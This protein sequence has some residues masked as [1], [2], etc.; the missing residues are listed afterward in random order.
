MH[1]GSITKL[2]NVVLLMQMVDERKVALED[3]VIKY[4][5][6]LRLCDREA[7]GRITVQM[8]V[9]HTSGIDGLWLPE[10]GPDQERIVDLIDRCADL[11]QLFA[12]GEAASYCNVAPVIAGYLTQKLRGESW[13]ALVKKRL[14]EP[15]GM[16]HALVDPLDVPRFR[17]SVGDVTNP[18]TGK[19]AQTARPFL[20]PSFAPAGSTQMTTA[21]D[22]ITFARMLLNTGVGPDGIRILSAAS[23][24]RMVQPTARFFYPSDWQVGLGWMILPGNVLYHSGGGRGVVSLLYAH[25]ESGRAVALLTN[26]DRGGALKATMVDPILESWTGIKP[27]TLQR[28]SGPVDSALYEG[29]YENNLMRLEVSRSDESL[30]VRQGANGVRMSE[31]YDTAPSANAVLHPLGDHLFEAEYASPGA[32]RVEF[33]FVPSA[34]GSDMR[35]MASNG[36]L[37]ARTQ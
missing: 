28:T 5:P 25:P 14:Y 2:M 24:A 9:N 35:F 1:I 23:I 27:A 32:P 37:L 19:L 10:Y 17:C 11:K 29:I 8:L 7:L 26:C 15:L 22:L 6:E 31:L 36:L 13:Y 4:L 21:T 18:A 33:Q 20:A 12:P 34:S 30:I 16:R 3:P